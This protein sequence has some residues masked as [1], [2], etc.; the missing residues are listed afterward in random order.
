MVKKSVSGLNHTVVYEKMQS[1]AVSQLDQK[2]LML[3]GPDKG[4]QLRHQRCFQSAV[5]EL[6]YLVSLWT[7]GWCLERLNSQEHSDPIEVQKIVAR[8]L[9][10]EIHKNNQ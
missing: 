4:I 3:T 10:K 6:N 8:K 5:Q 2:Q 7:V 9:K 1:C